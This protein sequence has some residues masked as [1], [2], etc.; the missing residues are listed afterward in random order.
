[1]GK[2]NRFTS[3]EELKASE[4]R[5]EA[6]DKILMRHRAFEKLM[7]LIRDKVLLKSKQGHR[8]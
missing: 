3:F 7:S 4:S 2:V 8:P 5:A 6:E 1:M